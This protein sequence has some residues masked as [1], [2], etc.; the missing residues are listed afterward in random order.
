MYKFQQIIGEIIG[1]IFF[2]KKLSDFRFE[3][4]PIIQFLTNL[5]TEYGEAEWP[6]LVMMFRLKMAIFGLIPQFRRL[7]YKT[8]K[9]RRNSLYLQK[10]LLTVLLVMQKSGDPRL[11]YSN[12]DVGSE[13]LTFSAISMEIGFIK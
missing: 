12:E 6:P 13:F 5:M 10:Y 8:S 1:H 3:G 4:Q 2:G 9:D 11:N 7:I